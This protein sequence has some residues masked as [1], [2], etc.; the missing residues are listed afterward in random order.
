MKKIFAIFSALLLTVSAQAQTRVI[1]NPACDEQEGSIIHLVKVELTDT[2]TILHINVHCNLGGWSGTNNYIEANGKRYAFRSGRR[3]PTMDGKELKE[4]V[5][6]PT[7]SK[8][9]EKTGTWLVK[10][11]E[12]PFV[13]GKHYTNT[14]QKDSLILHFEPL[15][16]DVTV[17]DV[18]D[19]IR[20]VSLI[21]TKKEEFIADSHLL[22]MPDATPEQFFD[23]VAALFPGKVVF[24]DLWATWCGPCKYGII[25]MRPVKEELKDKDVV[26]VYLTNESSP[27]AAWRSSIGS[28]KGYHLRMSSSFWN[29]LPCIVA[30]SGI[31]QYFLYDRSGKYLYSQIGFGDGSPQSFKEMILKALEE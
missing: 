20:N 10:G 26:F 5:E 29:K 13:E 17:F 27:E 24:I 3:I 11:G 2:A 18:G 1:L 25:K 12:E 23:A 6:I 14:S 8:A 15:P 28:I 30:N 7:L 21:E 19:D 9:G 31:P 4:D 16:A 22:V